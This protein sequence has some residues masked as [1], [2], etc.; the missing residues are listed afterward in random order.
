[1]S[2]GNSHQ[3]AVAKAASKDSKH[4]KSTDAAPPRPNGLTSKWLRGIRLLGKFIALLTVPLGLIT[5]YLSLIP[6]ISISQSQSINPSDAFATPFVVSN[7]GPLGINNVGF[8]CEILEILYVSAKPT[9]HIILEN[10][11][12]VVLGMEP[13]ERTS[14]RCPFSDI[15]IPVVG[16]YKSLDVVMRVRFRSDFVPWYQSRKFRFATA[17]LANGE[18]YWYPYAYSRLPQKD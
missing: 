2:G 15:A 13:G 9:R 14:F 10:F 11:Q 18:L 5:G 7:D 6:H 4:E 3:R 16:G 1:M 12:A 17:K 8:S